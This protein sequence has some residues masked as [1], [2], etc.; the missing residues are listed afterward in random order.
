MQIGIDVG[1]TKIKLG[2]FT[3]LEKPQISN[4][5]TISTSNN[6]E[7]DIKEVTKAIFTLSKG[8]IEGIGIGLPGVLNKEKSKI[9]IANNLKSWE[10]KEIKHEF[11]KRFNCKVV[12][13]NDATAAALGEALYGNGIN[14]DFLF[15]TWGTGIGGTFVKKLNGRIYTFSSELGHQIIKED[16][17]IDSCGQKGCLEA[18]CGGKGIENLYEKSPAKLLDKEWREVEESFAKGLLNIVA[19]HPVELI[20]FSGGIALNQEIRISH[21]QKYSLII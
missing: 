15:I 12:I 9:L 7:E 4:S 1:G 6:C 13:E 16:G 2:S 3:S 21:I 17:V 20:I 10:N 5:I 18:Y 8:I 11:E 14:K 19:I